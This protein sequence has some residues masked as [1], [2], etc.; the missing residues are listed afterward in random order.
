MGTFW[1]QLLL[2]FSF[3]CFETLKMFST[4]N[5]DV[6]VVLVQY[7]GYFF[8]YFFSTFSAL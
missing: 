7:L 2:Q 3:D 8:D 6:H 5:E 4:W 1:A